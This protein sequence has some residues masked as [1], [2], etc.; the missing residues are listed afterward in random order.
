MKPF[1]LMNSGRNSPIQLR[2]DWSL[3]SF[4]SLLLCL[5]LLASNTSAFASEDANRL[6]RVEPSKTCMVQNTLYQVDQN[7]VVVDGKTYYACCMPCEK[8]L[9]TDP[10]SRVAIDPI[11]KKSIDKSLAVVGATKE[12]KIHYFETEANL[13]LFTP[14]SPPSPTT[15]GASQPPNVE[16]NQAGGERF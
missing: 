8:E 15:E 5:L 1:S 14:S 9:K 6:K 10:N 3:M 11:S 2:T 7:K 13:K 12:G 4:A 16:Q